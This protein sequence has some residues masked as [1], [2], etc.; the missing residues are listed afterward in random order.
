MTTGTGRGQAPAWSLR[1]GR[2][3]LRR[4]GAG[5]PR[6]SGIGGSVHLD[7]AMV[8]LAE[9][10]QTA[11]REGPGPDGRTVTEVEFAWP[12]IDVC[13][14]WRIEPGADALHV[15]AALV[16]D[17]PSTVTVGDW[18]IL[19]LRADDGGT[20]D[21]GSDPANVRFFGWRP[22]DM[23]VER[24]GGAG[25]S[26]RSN[27]LLHLYDPVGGTTLLCGFVTLDRMLVEHTLDCSVSGGVTDW[28]ATCRFGA[29]DLP[30]GAELAGETLRIV[31]HDDPHAALEAWADAVHDR[32][33]PAFASP[34]TA[35]YAGGA[36]TDA[37]SDAEE[38]WESILLQCAEAIRR[39]LPG[40]GVDCVGGT[41]HKMYRQG[42]P[43]NWY[44]VDEKHIPHGLPALMD[45]LRE[46]GFS[47]KFWF[48][49][50]WF[51]AEA[52]GVLEANRENLLRDAA[53]EPI[54]EPATWEWDTR[55]DP[56]DTPRL[57][58]YY[59]DGTH[60][61]TQQYVRD[62]FL[63]NR[64][65]GVRAYML[66]FLSIK[67]NAR[68]HDPRLLPVEAARRILRVIREAAGNDTHL[69]TAVASTPGF[70][71]LID[72]ARVG[73]DFGEGR[74]MA[75][76]HAWRNA[77]YCLHD[78]HFANTHQFV[79]NAAANWFTHRKVYV[80]DLNCLTVDKPVP[81]EHARLAVTMFGLAGG[82][83]VTLGDD[84]RRVD[85]ERLRMIALC[86]PRTEGMPV[87]VDLFDRVWP[88]DYCRVLKLPV[89]TPWESY[90]LAAVYNGDATPFATRL[91]F[92]RLGLDGA[93][94]W[95]V[96]DFWNE[97]YLG[98]FTSSCPVAVPS[99]A[100]RLYRLS[101]ARPHPW[102]LSTDMHVQQG[103]VEIASLRWD[104]ASMTL[105]GTAARPAGQPG[106]VFIHI[107]RRLRL[108]NHRG[109]NLAKDVRD[110]TVVARLPLT[111]E[112]DRADFAL[113]F[114]PLRTRYVTRKRWLPYATEDE[115][116]AYVAEHRE[117]GDTR[118]VE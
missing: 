30:A 49:P 47:H 74:P 31:C 63:H 75:P 85:P 28:R 59:L 79:Q 82:S 98:T 38:T 8:S 108:I 55:S 93:A 102:L 35:N 86:L 100:M 110:M 1:D 92:A 118:V 60:P 95:R 115:W 58:K 62:I 99:A 17:G 57:T 34:A 71:G 19:H 6:L 39:R 80:N 21:L 40:L 64:A 107:P 51:F 13:W 2:L 67:P 46:M 111:F 43:G 56:D 50:F 61:R 88:D 89:R 10:T 12:D 104:E 81:L 20:M 29:Y 70:I 78:E 26:H 18:N 106:S 105:S 9:A 97:E 113:R 52:E 72:A 41:S 42:I 94:A 65:L 11:R 22:W 77:T 109:V 87:P 15:T 14:R 24:L 16:N 48:S 112:R 117:A 33:R 66:D 32:Y 27:N 73:R 25:G 101:P 44:E 91:D 45:R 96:F 114:E 84:I 90:T 4:P 3:E 54:R 68:L 5:A 83:P 53:G 23:R 116:L 36:W 69:Q 103:A 76:Y 7:G 37:F